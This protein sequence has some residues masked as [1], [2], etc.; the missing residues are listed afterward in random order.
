MAVLDA[1]RRDDAL[2]RE[3]V[4]DAWMTWSVLGRGATHH[5]SGLSHCTVIRFEAQVQGCIG[6]S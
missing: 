2:G 3:A 5:V 1:L 4:S 6:C